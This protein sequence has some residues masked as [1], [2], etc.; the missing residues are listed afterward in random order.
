V[1]VVLS[2]VH[3]KGDKDVSPLFSYHPAEL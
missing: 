1:S 3:C 2:S